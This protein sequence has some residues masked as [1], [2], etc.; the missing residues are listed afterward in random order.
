MLFVSTR[1]HEKKVTA[2]QAI[3]TGIAPDGG[4]YVPETFPK[5][6]MQ[7][8]KS[9]GQMDY[10]ERTA[11]VLS[12][13]LTE[14]DYKKLE[15]AC[16]KAYAKFDGDPAPMVKLDENEFVLEL[17]HGPTH[18]FKDMALTVLPYLLKEGCSLR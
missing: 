13:Y 1:G 3:T 17:Y 10:A 4:L 2:S 11:F 15:D 16:K 6:G 14:Y 9:L 18:A 5:L 7:E 8:L 12:K